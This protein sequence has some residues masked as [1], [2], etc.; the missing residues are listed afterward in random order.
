M[1]QHGQAKA[2]S[3]I[4][5]L[6]LF[7]G[8]ILAGFMKIADLAGIDVRNFAITFSIYL[9]MCDVFNISGYNF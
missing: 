9:K 4:L 2:S 7:T 3:H 5:G 1:L 6:L 8:Q